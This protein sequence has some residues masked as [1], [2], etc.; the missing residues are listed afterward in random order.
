MFKTRLVLRWE[1]RADRPVTTHV[2]VRIVSLKK[3]SPW[4]LGARRS[5]S[6]S[7]YLPDAYTLCATVED[8]PAHLAG[9]HVRLDMPGLEARRLSAGGAAELGL[10]T[11]LAPHGIVVSARPSA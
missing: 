11:P 10:V 3:V 4:W 6:V 5:P 1:G 2:T 7:G 9:R 8:G